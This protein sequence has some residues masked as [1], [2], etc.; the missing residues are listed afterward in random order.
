MLGSSINPNFGSSIVAHDVKLSLLVKDLL[1]LRSRHYKESN[2]EKKYK[3]YVYD[4][5]SWN[6]RVMVLTVL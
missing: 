1:R 2:E 5:K 6:N 4:K 3:G